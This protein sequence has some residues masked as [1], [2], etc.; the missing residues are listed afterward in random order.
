VSIPE[1]VLAR[2]KALAA[3]RDVSV[4]RY[5]TTLVVRDL[6]ARDREPLRVPEEL[7]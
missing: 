2:A 6:D 5:V 3:E 7:P 1:G 4:S